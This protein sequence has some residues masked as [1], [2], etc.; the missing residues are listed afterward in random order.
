MAVTIKH[1]MFTSLFFAVAIFYLCFHSLHG[2]QGLYAL[3]VQSH[4]QK[5]LEVELQE[6][7]AK[8]LFL[9]HKVALMRDG[10]V[11]PDLL[12]EEVRRYLGLVGKDEIIV[13]TSEK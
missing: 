8:R 3:L 13:I 1:K 5:K 10:S 6:V 7:K 9:E 2:E 4:N 11:D 12:D